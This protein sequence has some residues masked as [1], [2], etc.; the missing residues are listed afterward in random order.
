VDIADSNEKTILTFTLIH[1]LGHLLTLNSN[2][3]KVNLPVY[4]NPDDKDIYQR[5]ADAC[6][7]YFTGE[8]CS[9]PGSYINLFFDRFW[10]DFYKEWQAFDK[11]ADED[12]RF[13][14][15]DE[16]YKTYQDHLTV[17]APTSPR[18]ISPKHGHSSSWHPNPNS[19]PL[20]TKRFYFLR[21]S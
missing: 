4:R 15:L 11:E 8:G 13:Q 5:E 21:I 17:Y 2:Q 7:Q 14:M 6:P 16:F 9:N 12:T 1:E 3:V 19:R 20:P 10:I 18:R